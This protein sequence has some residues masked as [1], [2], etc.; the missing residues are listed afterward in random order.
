MT[1]KPINKVMH[2][3]EN[4]CGA[5]REEDRPVLVGADISAGRVLRLG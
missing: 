2:I 3:I 4:A 5:V 1:E